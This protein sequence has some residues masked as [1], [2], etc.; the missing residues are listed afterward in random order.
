MSGHSK[1]KKIKHQKG[2]ADQKRGQIFSKLL[3]AISVAAKDESNPQFNPRL[4]ST[5][6]KA[7][8]NNVPLENIE[9]A[10]KR[11]QEVKDFEELTMEAYGPEG[12][13]VII[14]V[15]TD[16]RNRAVSEIK[17]IINDH[18]AKWAD[19]GS[20]LWAFEKSAEYG[21]GWQAKFP[22]EISAEGKEKLQN[23]IEALEEHNNVQGVYTNS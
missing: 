13:A 14:E 11:S 4:R 17:K 3:A 5:I 18:N 21:G 20:V 15:I 22:Q 7:R 8:Q 1:W 23:L 9:R 10:I 16:N 12:S 6:E 19:S 2:A